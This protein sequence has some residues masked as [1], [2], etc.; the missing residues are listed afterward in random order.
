MKFKSSSLPAFLLG[1]VV[2]LCAPSAHAVQ[3]RLIGWADPDS[4]LVFDNKTKAVETTLSPA[5]FSA[6]YEFTGEGALVLYK[7]VE[8]EGKIIR[9]TAC[10]V[11]IPPGLKQGLLLLFPGDESQVLSRKVQPD[12]FGTVSATA[13][14]AYNYVWFDD[15]LEARPAGT[16]QFLNLSARQ[17]AL[18]VASQQLVLPPKAKALANLEAGSKRM[19]FQGAVQVDGRWTIFSRKPIPTRDPERMLVILR[20]EPVSGPQP[21]IKLV[22]LFDWRAPADPTLNPLPAGTAITLR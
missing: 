12:S 6:S 20:E 17:L 13:P 11:A 4:N 3:F 5:A 14:L 16:I 19:N 22:T 10:T 2:A 7:R 18:Q 15:S 9:Q 21:R 8:H 1:F